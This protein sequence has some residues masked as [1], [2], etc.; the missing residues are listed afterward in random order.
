[1]TARS[2]TGIGLNDTFPEFGSKELGIDT[3]A[4]GIFTR[5]ILL[6]MVDFLGAREA[7][8][9]PDGR[10]FGLAEVQAL[11]AKLNLSLRPG[12]G[13]I[14]FTGFQKRLG[15]N[16]EAWVFNG[17]SYNPIAPGLLAETLPLWAEAKTIALISD[18]PAVEPMPMGEGPLHEGALKK[19]GIYLAELWALERLVA[20][21]RAS[22][23]YEFALASVPL[24]IKGAFGSPS[25]AIAI[26]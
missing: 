22:N 24:D 14:F 9:L 1:M 25:N 26:L 15:L 13:I 6:D 19:H 18:N 5:A 10:N 7:G 20:H 23:V 21:C 4:G 11:L 2:T 3:L 8:F 16:P 12:D 17:P